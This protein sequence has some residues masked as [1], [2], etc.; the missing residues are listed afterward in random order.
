MLGKNELSLNNLGGSKDLEGNWTLC[1]SHYKCK[2]HIY[3]VKT[4]F[5]GTFCLLLWKLKKCK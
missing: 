1:N 3:H 4:L 2:C 5:N